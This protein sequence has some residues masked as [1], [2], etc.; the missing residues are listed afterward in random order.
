MTNYEVYTIHLDAMVDG[1]SIL[2]ATICMMPTDKR[3]YLPL[4]Q[5]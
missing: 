4:I 2:S 3:A 5:R 1:V